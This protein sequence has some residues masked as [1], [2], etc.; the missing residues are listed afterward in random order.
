MIFAD[1]AVSEG[2][3]CIVP[4]TTVTTSEPA[5]A[6]RVCNVI[7]NAVPKLDSCLLA[8]LPPIEISIVEQLPASHSDCFAIYDCNNSRMEI[9]APDKI[10]LCL[11]PG[12]FFHTLD[13]DV[14]F[15]SVIVHELTHAY[16]DQP[17]SQEI[18]SYVE[19]E[20]LAYAMQF[21]F[22]PEIDRVEILRAQEGR[23]PV[24]LEELNT[25][26]LMMAPDVFGQK[27]WRHF[28]SP[29]NGCAFVQKIISGE[30]DLIKEEY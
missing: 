1:V 20:Y 18:L 5:L 17:V 30:I 26:V 15:D 16:V 12:N 9:L 11:V 22:L 19:Q 13:P 10:A 27:A 3:E 25:T 4:G 14:L 28:V 21:G 7:S 24:T 29:G 6:R 8:Q 23:E 2:Y